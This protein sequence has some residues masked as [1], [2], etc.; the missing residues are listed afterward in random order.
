MRV[1]TMRGLTLAA[2]VVCGAGS[3][4]AQVR[5]ATDI[6]AGR[7]IGPDSTPIAGA[8]VTAVAVMTNVTKTVVTNGD[9]RFSVVFHDG[10]GTYRIQVTAIGMRPARAI[11]ERRANQDR[12]FVTIR[13]SLQS[14]E[15]SPVE[16]RGR[17]D[18]VEAAFTAGGNE[19]TLLPQLVERLQANPG[20]LFTAATLVPGV[21]ATAA[22]DTSRSAFSFAAQPAVQNNITVDGMTFL[23]GSIPQDA[24]RS[25]RLILNA[26]DVSR[27]QFTGAQMAT[28]TKGGTSVFQGSANVLLQPKVTQFAPTTRGSFAREYSR[29]LL[30]TGVGGPVWHTQRAF[31]FLAGELDARSDESLSLT[32][33]TSAALL[34]LG[35]S[36]D[37]LARLNTALAALGVPVTQMQPPQRTSSGTALARADVDL[38]AAN[39]L[40]LRADFRGTNQDANRVSPYALADARGNLDGLGGGALAVLTSAM[41]PFINEARA[42]G[43]WERNDADPVVRMPTGVVRLSSSLDGTSVQDVAFGA[44]ARLPRTSR[45]TLQE[46]SDELSWLAEEDRHRLRIGVLINR[47]RAEITGVDD[48]YGSFRYNSLADLESN[49]PASF[50]RTM[51]G[52]SQLIGTDNAAIYISHAW[53]RTPALQATYGLRIDISRLADSPESNTLLVASLN[54]QTRSFLTE[55]HYLPRLGVTYL[56]GDDP[57]NPVGSVSFGFG[58]FRGRIPSH[59]LQYVNTNAGFASSDSQVVCVGAVTPSVNW[60]TLA[61][62]TLSI[63]TDCTPGVTRL[64]LGATVSKIG[65]WG[66]SAGSPRVWRSALSFQRRI[67]R[68]YDV[69]FDALYAHGIHN[70]AAVDDNL[71]SAPPPFQLP[72]LANESRPLLVNPAAIVSST[73]AISLSASREYPFFGTVYELGSGVSSR[74]IEVTVHGGIVA[75]SAGNQ[76]SLAYTFTRSRDQSNGF[77]FSDSYPTTAGDP[78]FLEWG[79]SDLERRHHVLVIGL[80]QLPRSMELGVVGRLMS[81]ARFTPMVNG[82]VNGDGLANDRAFVFRPLLALVGDSVS[83]AMSRLLAR[84]DGRTRACLATQMGTIAGRNSCTTPWYAGLDLQLNWRPPAPLSRGTTVSLVATNALSL[85]DR[86]LHGA[87]GMR[88]WGQTSMPDRNLLSVTGYDAANRAF[89]YVV[90]EHFGNRSGSLDP[91]RTPFQLGLIVRTQFG[92]E[93]SRPGDAGPL[94]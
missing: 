48:R 53:R 49:T 73:G 4:A 58:E 60:A 50:S 55:L 15:L 23:F 84:A 24:V 90:N 66:S 29:A 86:V 34:K 27:G 56:L 35:V 42:Y 61:A 65:V 14:Q 12:L 19:R 21:I 68:R 78:R 51:P 92:R 91:F 6:I 85:A 69:G 83:N 30:S 36:P 28:V 74:T 17:V 45:A 43:S 2:L 67:G 3:A 22:S 70:P 16:V 63:P 31:Y 1:R 10:D 26:Y 93:H 18:A 25:T 81:G 88:G 13:M 8:R 59:L 80:F 76:L 79:T 89:R 11:A 33:S 75:D 71:L 46:A 82:D 9:G 87:A 32:N 40:T 47:E 62:D 39:Q 57:G 44:N 72:V 52:R 7:V 64:P 94:R 37:S 77:P 20:D 5:P 38:T 41:G 54:Q